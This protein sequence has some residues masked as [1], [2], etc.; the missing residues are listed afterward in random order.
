MT[1]TERAVDPEPGT[2]DRWHEVWIA[3]VIGIGGY[4]GL[5]VAGVVVAQFVLPFTGT[6]SDLGLSVVSAV[7]TGVGAVGVTWVYFRNSRHDRSFL[8]LDPP[9]LRD[10]GYVV[11]GLLGLVILLTGIS[12]LANE[13]GITFSQHSI[14]E[15]A[16]DGNAE[17]LLVLIP[18]S[19]L[20][21][22]PGEELIYRNLVQKRLEETFSPA[23]AVGIAS[24]IFGSIHLTAYATSSASAPQILGSLAIV[25]T[26]S[27]VLGWL[28][29][30]TEKLIVPALVHGLFNAF[31]F[32]LL[33]VDIAG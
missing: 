13:L 4:L 24:I 23:V 9:G 7:A 20:F 12:V 17:L 10:L 5:M 16:R 3:F 21:V 29:V 27:V 19:I 30:R 22:G 32:A 8:D 1:E 15:S 31:Q 18:F 11:A 2:D 6:L 25:G 14:E 28:Y 26:L 33:Y